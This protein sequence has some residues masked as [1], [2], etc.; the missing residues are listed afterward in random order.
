M[1]RTQKLEKFAAESRKYDFDFTNQAEIVAGQTLTGTPTV[2]S[3][4]SGLTLGT[5]VLDGTSKK[6]Q[7]TIS[8]GTVNQMYEVTALVNTSGGAILEGCGKLLIIEC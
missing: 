5:A 4:P 2:S 1:A 7:V 8:G 3:S 6:V